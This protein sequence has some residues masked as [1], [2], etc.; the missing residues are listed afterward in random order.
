MPVPQPQE[1]T[2]EPA[3]SIE[4]ISTTNDTPWRWETPQ[5]PETNTPSGKPQENT[6]QASAPPS[7]AAQPPKKRNF[8]QRLFR[9]FPRN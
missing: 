7:P 3:A 8:F 4:P 5:P 2:T 6:Q 1:K 9:K